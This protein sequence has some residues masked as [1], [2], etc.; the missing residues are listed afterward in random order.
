MLNIYLLNVF[1]C[2]F[3]DIDV[4]DNPLL[5]KYSLDAADVNAFYYIHQ[6]LEAIKYEII[7]EKDF[8]QSF[9]YIRLQANLP[10]ISEKSA[11]L[12]SLQQTKKN[13]KIFY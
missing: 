9:Y 12:N 3:Q 5:I 11:V 1:I 13:V 4:T 8:W 2:L 7:P 6:K 10:F